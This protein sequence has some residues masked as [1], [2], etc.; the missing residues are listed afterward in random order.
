MNIKVVWEIY[1]EIRQKIKAEYHGLWAAKQ[2]GG[3]L[4]GVEVD[5]SMFTHI[6]LEGVKLQVWNI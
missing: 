4:Q 3:L 1:K 6:T 5:E 2:L